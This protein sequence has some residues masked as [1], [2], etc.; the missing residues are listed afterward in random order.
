MYKLT[1]TTTIIRLSDAASIPADPANTD[2]AAYLVW[3]SQGNTPEPYVEP[4]KPTPTTVS[5]VQ[6][7]L[8]LHQMNLLE[9]VEAGISSM[10]KVAQIEWEFR[11]TV[12]RDSTL[13]LALAAA[14]QLDTQALDDLFILADTL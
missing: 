11:A 12:Q 1:N 13:V 2:Y 4:P 6:A 14:L 9:S 8:A 5:M 3:L 7:R 10:G